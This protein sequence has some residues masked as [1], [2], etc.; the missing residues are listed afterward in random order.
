MTSLRRLCSK[1]IL[2]VAKFDPPIARLPALAARTNVPDTEVIRA[3]AQQPSERHVSF[4][5]LCLVAM[6]V[7]PLHPRLPEFLRRHFAVFI[8]VAAF[9]DERGQ[10]VLVR[11]EL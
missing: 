4:A 6:L 5:G 11:G 7:A 10:Q 2:H 1:Q 3:F 8:T 9:L